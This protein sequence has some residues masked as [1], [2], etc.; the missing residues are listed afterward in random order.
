MDW[1]DVGQVL[2]KSAPYLGSILLGPM[3]A[4]VGKIIADTLGTSED[5]AAVLQELNTNPEAV[6]KL[7][8]IESNERIRTQE[9]ANALASKQLESEVAAVQSVNETMRA[10]AGSEHWQTYSWRPALGFA[11]AFNTVAASLLVLVA[12]ALTITNS[13]T[14][15]DM[16]ASLP[17]VLGALA[18]INA[19][20]LPVLG[21]ASWYRGKMQA[22]PAI[23]PSIPIP[24][25]LTK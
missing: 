12:F 8:E 6:L 10:E 22:D 4:G 5:P 18:A 15:G 25:K 9:L 14:A 13:L 24:R 21:I 20:V 11:V 7:R 23:P 19:T 3:G 1:K 16:I 2:A 17:G